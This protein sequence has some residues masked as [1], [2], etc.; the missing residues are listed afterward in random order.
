MEAINTALEKESKLKDH[1]GK[2]IDHP[3]PDCRSIEEDTERRRETPAK[4]QLSF[5]LPL[6]MWTI[7]KPLTRLTPNTLI[8]RKAW[9]DATGRTRS[10]RA[11][12]CRPLAPLE[13]LLA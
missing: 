2:S 1:G 13:D 3:E 11:I 6:V 7:H 10:P 8:A 9:F 4:I 5:S 12:Y